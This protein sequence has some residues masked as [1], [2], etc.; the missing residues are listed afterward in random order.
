MIEQPIRDYIIHH[1]GGGVFA[2]RQGDWKLIEGS[3]EAGYD[4]GP[5][6]GAPGQLN[7]LAEDPG[8]KNDLWDQRPDIVA[9]LTE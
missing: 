8:E 2:I 7:N 3:K 6:P 4:D 1:S 9:R 5:T